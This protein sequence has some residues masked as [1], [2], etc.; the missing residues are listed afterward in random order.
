MEASSGDSPV[1]LSSQQV[2]D[3][4]DQFAWAYRRYWGDHIHHGLFRTGQ[5]DSAQAQE[6]MLRHCAASAGVQAGML[7]VDVGCGHGGT[8][9]F[10]ATEYSC[11]VL[12]LTISETQLKLAGKLCQALN[13]AVRFEL[14]DA[15]SYVFPAA[16][17]DV[18]WN[19]E[20]SEHFFDKAA[21]FR[22]IAAALK[23]GGRLMLA[24][25]SGSMQDQLVRNVARVFLCPQLW[26]NAEYV[27]QIESA[28]LQVV[29][30]EQLAAEVVRTWDIV[31]ENV[32]NSH[33]LLSILPAQFREFAQGIELMRTG[34]RDGQLSYSIV[35][36]V[37]NSG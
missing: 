2:R 13:G 6:L 14:A 24:A 12:G 33:W 10:L 4:Y 36:A 19:M 37:K 30:S 16:G 35:V 9:S 7:V 32:R 3:H 8:A 21:Y 18:I 11:K 23:P 27:A 28:G 22:K 29:S 34:Y 20:S 15:E 1:H 31:A 26:T 5:E 17:F 25:W